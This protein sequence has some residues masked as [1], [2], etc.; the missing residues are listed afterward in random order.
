MTRNPIKKNHKYKSEDINPLFG[1][2]ATRSLASSEYRSD[3][4]SSASEERRWQTRTTTRRNTPTAYS[5]T[6]TA[7]T[8]L[9]S[10]SPTSMLSSVMF[11]DVYTTDD[12]L[13][14]NNDDNVL[15]IA[16][17]MTMMKTMMLLIAML[18]TIFMM[19]LRTRMKKH[20]TLC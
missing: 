9:R 20:C 8:R 18:M 13:N 17:L 12:N 4:G 11:E 10:T 5:Y 1:S 6:P 16:V 19:V 3:D 14:G 7:G 15:L 2:L